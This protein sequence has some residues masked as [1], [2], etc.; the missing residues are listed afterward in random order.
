MIEYIN[1]RLNEWAIWVLRRDENGLGYPRQCAWSRMTPRSGA[2]V[3]VGEVNDRA[4]EVE[5]AVQSLSP[6]LQE[7]IRV[8]YLMNSTTEQKEKKLRCT[9]HT[10]YRKL[11]IAHVQIMDFL[12]MMDIRDS[13]RKENRKNTVDDV[14]TQ[15][16]DFC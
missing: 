13:I 3:F 11:N 12:N 14:A 16:V 2:N 5:L 7:F 1:N 6:V 9:R 8:F 4:Y 15:V 10:I